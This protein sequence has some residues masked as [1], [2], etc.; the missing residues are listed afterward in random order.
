MSGGGALRRRE[1]LA[2][3]LAGTVAVPVAAQTPTNGPRRGAPNVIFVVSDQHRAGMTKAEGYPLDTSPGLDALARRG[4][5]FEHAYATAPLCVPSR[6]SML[7]GRWPE[8]HHVR[9]NTD[10]RD[11]YY[12]QDIYDVA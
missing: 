12:A 5:R 11:A 3:L 2:T 9:M 1:L 6:C 8:A 4:V 10:A 7:T